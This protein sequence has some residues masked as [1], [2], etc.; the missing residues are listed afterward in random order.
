MDPSE[1][2]TLSNLKEP[3]LFQATPK[4]VHTSLK[5]Q[6]TEPKLDF[7]PF[8]NWTL[9]FNKASK[10]TRKFKYGSPKRCIYFQVSKIGGNID[11]YCEFL[12]IILTKEMKNI[13][14]HINQQIVINGLLGGQ[15]L[16]HI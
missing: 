12:I 8:R 13:N 3:S 15:F 7:I 1:H 14:I 16:M 5:D 4:E 2:Q 6:V 9:Q 11:I 10:K